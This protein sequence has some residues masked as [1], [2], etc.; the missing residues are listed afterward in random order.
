MNRRRAKRVTI[1]D[2]AHEAGVSYSTVSRVVNNKDVVEEKTRARVIQAI[3]KLGYVVN[4][5]ARSLA[6]GSS[7]VIGLL[8]RDLGTGYIGEIIR[9][10]D[11]EIAQTQYDLMLYTTHRH[12]TDE[13]AYVIMMTQGMADGLLL[14]LP[15]QPEAYLASL[16][17]RSFPYM[18][19]DHQGIAENEAAVA[20]ENWQGGFVA[21]EHLLQLGHRRIGF[22]TGNLTMGCAQ[23]RRAGYYAALTQYGIKPDEALVKEGNFFQPDGYAAG[24]ALL[25]LPQPPTAI[26]ASNDVMAF[27]VMESVRDRGLKIPD[28]VSIVGFDDIPQSAY[29]HPP[30]TTVRQPLEEMGRVAVR[31]LL[32]MIENPDYSAPRITLPIELI[33]RQS[34][35]TL[36]HVNNMH[37]PDLQGGE[38][39]PTG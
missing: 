24:Q 34:C 29:V 32:A 27:G 23:N 1:M 19:I 18:L 4:R 10:I 2:V 20:V 17:E 13:S 26:F 3:N 31:T 33:V 28:D 11:D 30:L 12:K 14:V 16:R 35:C 37:R 38:L 6:G 9:G 7:Q 39:Q 15:R 22:V 36:D 5:Q 25:S 21:T 8:V